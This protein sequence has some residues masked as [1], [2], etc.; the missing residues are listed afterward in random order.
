MFML[1]AEL[2]AQVIYTPVT[3]EVYSFLDRLASENVIDNYYDAA[4][5]L[6]REEIASYL[7]EAEKSS[8]MLS[9]VEKQELSWYETDYS[10]ELTGKFGRWRLFQYADTLF[11]VS[12][13]PMI[14]LQ[15]NSLGGKKGYR[16]GWL[17]RFDGSI[18]KHVGFS[19]SITDNTE[20]GDTLDSPEEL[21]PATGFNYKKEGKNSISYED[22]NA[23]LNYSWSWG[24]FTLG[25]DYVNWGSGR[26]GQLILSSKAPSFPFIK[27]DIYPVSWLRF[28]Y[29]HGWLASNI[30]DS[31]SI[32]TSTDVPGGKVYYRANQRS[33]YI[34]AN[35]LSLIPWKNFMFSI[36]NS[37]VYSDGDVRIPFLIPFIWYYK[38]IDHDLYGSTINDEYGDN[39]Q[40]FFDLS[41]RSLEHFHF[42]GTWFVD[43]LNFTDFLKGKYSHNQTG[44]TIG[45]T[46]YGSIIDN[47]MLELE[48]TKIMPGTY[49]NHIQTQTYENDDYILGDWIGQNADY[50]YAGINYELTRGMNA[51]LYYKI[52]RKGGDQLGTDFEYKGMSFLYKPLSDYDIE[53][54]NFSYEMLYDMNIKADLNY[55]KYSYDSGVS[56]ITNKNSVDFSFE[57]SYG[58]Y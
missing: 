32:Y 29:I 27:F 22:I 58:I 8:Y 33:K 49:L 34:A 25:K 51:G 48:Y 2:S 28:Q 14:D 47:L 5:P 45:A 40:L 31:S 6:S 24:T 50:L 43:E 39:G 20:Y 18:G 38:G 52:L 36:G 37:I 10:Y 23:T 41:V 15:A 57:V 13:S 1:A 21:T 35:M 17:G 55:T 56:P 42:Y 11:R 53:G 30:I 12:L 3:S 4:K 44:Y 16:E 7:K 46:N 26:E 9:T 19:F 54:I